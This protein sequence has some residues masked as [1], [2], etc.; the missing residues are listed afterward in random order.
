MVR[1]HAACTEN[2][3]PTFKPFDLVQNGWSKATDIVSQVGEDMELGLNDDAVGVNRSPDIEDIG[4]CDF[5]V[6]LRNQ[7]SIRHVSHTTR[8]C[9]TVYCA[10]SW[11]SGYHSNEFNSPVAFQRSNESRS[12]PTQCK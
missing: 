12:N 6:R 10:T 11:I 8:V 7:V 3:I 5:K 1:E 9:I 4:N 2:L